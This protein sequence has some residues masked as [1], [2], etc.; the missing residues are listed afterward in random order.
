MAFSAAATSGGI[1]NT[2][3]PERV[4]TYS[5][6]ASAAKS[7]E[8]ATLTAWGDG[9]APRRLRRTGWPSAC[10]APAAAPRRPRLPRAPAPA[11]ARARQGTRQRC[12][13]RAPARRASTAQRSNAEMIWSWR[14][15][16]RTANGEMCSMKLRDTECDVHS[17][18]QPATHSVSHAS[19]GKH[20]TQ[21]CAPRGRAAARAGRG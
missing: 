2:T 19:I 12:A 5:I 13:V 16:L 17:C 1:S 4:S 7:G 6:C 20:Q 15:K 11:A 9:C 3:C 18:T 10:R 8:E 14:G 21:R